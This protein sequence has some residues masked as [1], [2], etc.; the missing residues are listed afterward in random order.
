MHFDIRKKKRVLCSVCSEQIFPRGVKLQR[1]GPSKLVHNQFQ[2]HFRR[3]LSRRCEIKILKIFAK[4]GNNP[5]T[6]D[7][8]P[9]LE[10]FWKIRSVKPSTL[11]SSLLF[12]STAHIGCK[13]SANHVQKIN[14]SVFNSIPN[15]PRENQAAGTNQ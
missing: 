15:Q 2:Q 11:I 9:G 10:E 8:Q 13:T 12:R 3:R 7:K 1:Y 14:K 4:S 6:V 5:V